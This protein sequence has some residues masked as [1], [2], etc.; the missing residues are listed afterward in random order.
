MS[1]EDGNEEI[2]V[3]V[4]PVWNPSETPAPAFPCIVTSANPGPIPFSPV[5]SNPTG[6]WN[7]SS[8]IE[9][10]AYRPEESPAFRP[11][12][13]R[14]ASQNSPFAE[15]PLQGPWWDL[16]SYSMEDQLYSSFLAQEP[17]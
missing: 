4:E 11:W 5:P 12:E 8:L 13:W 10:L 3:G 7:P 2:D 6:E 16:P 14:P 15:N 1:L 9:S 17:Q